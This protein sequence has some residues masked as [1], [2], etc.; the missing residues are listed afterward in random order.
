MRVLIR[1]GFCVFSLDEKGIVEYK[2]KHENVLL[3]LH[4]ESYA[5]YAQ[6]V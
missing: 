6:M 2:V 4:Y 1:H 3:L 5:Y